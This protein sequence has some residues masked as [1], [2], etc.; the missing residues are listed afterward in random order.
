MLFSLRN[1]IIKKLFSKVCLLNDNETQTHLVKLSLADNGF[2][3]AV[4]ED[5][6]VSKT[7]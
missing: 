5:N 2:E 4:T 7:Q 6:M 3:N 1:E